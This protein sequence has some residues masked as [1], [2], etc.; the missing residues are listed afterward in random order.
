[1]KKLP[2]IADLKA[3]RPSPVVVPPPATAPRKKKA[4]KPS[5]DAGG[6]R[7]P[8]QQLMLMVPEDTAKALKVKA[9]EKDLTVRALV[10]KALKDAGYPVPKEEIAD[11]RSGKN[12]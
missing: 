9:A 8:G 12:T 4:S 3:T 11:R 5:N 7:G 6:S 10:L 2:S 1:M